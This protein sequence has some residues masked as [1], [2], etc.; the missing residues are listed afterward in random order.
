M[1]PNNQRLLELRNRAVGEQGNLRESHV[2]KVKKGKDLN[3]VKN[4]EG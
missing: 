2:K 4:F 1:D 3:E